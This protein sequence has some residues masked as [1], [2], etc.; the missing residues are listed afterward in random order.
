MNQP[1]RHIS[2]LVVDDSGVSRE[3]LARVLTSEPGIEVVGYARNGE[4]ALA[5]AAEKTPASSAS[6]IS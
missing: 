4:E 3:L 6:P 1:P 2:V 5:M